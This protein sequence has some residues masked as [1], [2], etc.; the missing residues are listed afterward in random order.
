MASPQRQQGRALQALRAI[1]VDSIAAQ[2][3][4]H[5]VQLFADLV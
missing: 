4:A 2:V 3:E 1:G 5:L